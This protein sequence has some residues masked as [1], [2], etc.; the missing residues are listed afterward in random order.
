MS[1]TVK[2]GKSVSV[3]AAYSN[4]EGTVPLV[5]IDDDAPVDIMA[6]Y[7]AF[8]ARFAD[9]QLKCWGYNGYGGL[10]LGDAISRGN[11]ANEMGVLLPFVNLGSNRS[12]K[13]I[14]LQM[15]TNNGFCAVLDDNSMRCWGRNLAGQLGLGDLVS[16]GDQVNETGNGTVPVDLGAGLYAKS[17]ARGIQHS[18]ALLNDNTVKC[19]GDNA[20]GQLGIGDT[21]D[22]GDQ[23][24]EMGAMLPTVNVGTNRTVVMLAA[25]GYHTCAVLDDKNVKCWG[26]G[27]FGQLGYGNTLSQG[28]AHLCNPRQRHAQVLGV[29]RCRSPGL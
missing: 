1:Y 5:N 25:G 9:A 24:N 8:C 18:C 26:R 19:W 29:R 22:R 17:L 16:R 4:L 15:A 2:L 14:P 21:A 28:V 12:V 11:D 6:S 10:A 23:P 3:D 27:N 13:S 20:Y 7:D